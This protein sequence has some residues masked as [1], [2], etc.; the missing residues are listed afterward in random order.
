MKLFSKS[1]AIGS[2]LVI[3]FSCSSDKEKQPQTDPLKINYAIRSLWPHDTEAF[4]QGLLIYNGQL[5]ES[6][7]QFGTSWIGIVDI[8]TGKVDKK[9]VLDN[10]YFGEGIAILNNKIFQL[11]WQNKIGFVY[12]LKTFRKLKEFKFDSFA[13]EGWGLTHDQ[14]NLIMSDGTNQLHYLDTATLELVKSVKVM[15][16]NGPVKNLNELEYI[17]GYVY[18]N[19]WQ[20]NL[21]LKIDPQSG[22]VVG[23]I[24]LS[25]LASDAR[26]ASPQ[27]DVLNGI[28]WHPETRSFLVTGK[29][30]PNIYILKID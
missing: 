3:T 22:K 11:T 13:K 15:D 17:E 9:V 19:V 20:T 10:Q 16:E 6:T 8:N 29:N 12:D 5:F 2:L 4:T 1:L 30:W 25:K 14:A 27:V 18:A 26:K 24:D 21:I 7:G 28:A 23:R